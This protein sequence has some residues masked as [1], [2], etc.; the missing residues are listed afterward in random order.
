MAWRISL[1]SNQLRVEH[2]IPFS[3]ARRDRILRLFSILF[4][5][6]LSKHEDGFGSSHPMWWSRNALNS[7]RVIPGELVIASA[8]RNPGKSKK[9]LDTRFRGY[10]GGKNGSSRTLVP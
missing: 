10:D 8:T 1:K 6:A 9:L 4:L 5:R 7:S 3:S 2:G